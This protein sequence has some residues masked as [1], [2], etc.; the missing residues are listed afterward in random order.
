M[1]QAATAN[2]ASMM[3]ADTDVHNHSDGVVVRSLVIG[4]AAFLTVVD[5]FATQAI[6]PSLALHYDVT[7][8]ATGFAVNASTMG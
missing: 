6:L 3:H 2:Q 8:A 7:P 4:L 1:L 5:L